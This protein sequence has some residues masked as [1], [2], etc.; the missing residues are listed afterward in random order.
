MPRLLAVL[1]RCTAPLVP[2]AQIK[3]TAAYHQRARD[4]AQAKVE[5]IRA[6]MGEQEAQLQVGGRGLR[7][8]VAAVRARGGLMSCC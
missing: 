5:S 6:R 4:E 1:Y 8:V 7:G 2:P 3:D